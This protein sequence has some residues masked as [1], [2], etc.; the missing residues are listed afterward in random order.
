MAPA[1]RGTGRLPPPQALPRART[2]AFPET[3]AQD[4]SKGYRGTGV[5]AAR[6]MPGHCPRGLVTL[7]ALP[8]A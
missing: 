3:S 4:N 8:L 6:H 1:P 2:A 7:D 5:G